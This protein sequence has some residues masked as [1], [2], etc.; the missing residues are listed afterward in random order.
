MRP[1]AE[2]PDAPKHAR[3]C[4][5]TNRSTPSNLI[6]PEG[7]RRASKQLV[8]DFTFTSTLI[9][10]TNPCSHDWVS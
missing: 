8:Y 4:T 2:A 6:G 1:W 3:H 7:H 5:A 10:A 9:V